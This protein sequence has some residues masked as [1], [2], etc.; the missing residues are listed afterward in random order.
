M[1]L[2]RIGQRQRRIDRTCG[3]RCQ[4]AHVLLS[5]IGIDHQLPFDGLSHCRIRVA[6]LLARLLRAGGKAKHSKVR[7]E[8]AE[9]H[10]LL[11]R[12]QWLR[13]RNRRSRLKS[14]LAL[15]PQPAKARA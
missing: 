15:A 6:A 4:I 12:P 3:N 2:G 7:D 9:I 8:T 5:Q 11:M 14:C 1:R 10:R 13:P